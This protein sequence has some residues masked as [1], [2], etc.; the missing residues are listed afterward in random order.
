MASA[1]IVCVELIGA[2]VFGAGWYKM[3]IRFLMGWFRYGLI[4][5]CCHGLINRDGLC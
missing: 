5:L 3:S 4:R 2:D 1:E